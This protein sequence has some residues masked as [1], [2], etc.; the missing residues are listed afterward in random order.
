MIGKR[1]WY[2]AAKDCRKNY[3]ANTLSENL[4]RTAKLR[5][6]IEGFKRAES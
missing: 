5:W 3:G 6:H 1:S 4:T 2:K